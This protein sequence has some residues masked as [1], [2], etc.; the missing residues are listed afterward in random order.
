MTAIHPTI[1]T[2][3]A[4]DL[5]GSEEY[6]RLWR[7]LKTAIR[8]PREFF[9]GLPVV[10]LTTA[11]GYWFSETEERR[12]ADGLRVDTLPPGQP[13]ART[14][15]AMPTSALDHRRFPKVILSAKSTRGLS[16]G[17]T[18]GLTLEID[19][20][21]AIVGV[22]PSEWP[23]VATPVLLAISV[24]WRLIQVVH[25]LDELTEWARATCERPGRLL[26]RPTLLHR[27]R[28]L[29]NRLLAMRRLVIDL[30]CYEGPLI[31][32]G[33]YFSSRPSARLYRALTSASSWTAGGPSST[34][35]SRSWRR[36]SRPGSRSG[37]TVM[38]SHA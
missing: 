24:C 38:C 37:G 1:L 16:P 29:G 8:V 4:I 28:E 14:E 36:R 3:V 6:D 22:D 18:N 9:P 13:A 25:Q 2:L 31:D 30:P 33:G 5:A 19:H 21:R 32:P 12:E 23:S 17:L 10:G 15:V 11:V 27:R 26:G 35:A 34:S 7:T 20:N